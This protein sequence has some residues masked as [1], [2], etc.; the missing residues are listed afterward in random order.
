M[1]N[2]IIII[3]VITII[4][5]IY[6]CHHYFHYFSETRAAIADDKYILMYHFWAVVVS[7]VLQSTPSL[8]SPFVIGQNCNELALGGLPVRT[9][10]A[11]IAM[12]KNYSAQRVCTVH[13][14]YV[15]STL[16]MSASAT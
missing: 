16:M 8:H 11:A 7:G 15:R 12:L 5:I 3:I 1:L 14:L 2:I 10:I 6:Y 9:R 4:I 13:V